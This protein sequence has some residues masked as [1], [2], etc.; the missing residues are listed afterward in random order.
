M[1]KVH[2]NFAAGYRGR[3]HDYRGNPESLSVAASGGNPSDK[4]GT[5]SRY[6]PNEVVLGRPDR[7]VL[8]PTK[9]C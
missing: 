5:K 2:E 6:G 1:E 3:H 9:S 7:V 8:G 4:G